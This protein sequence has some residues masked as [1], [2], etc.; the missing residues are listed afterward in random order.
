MVDK[1][2]HQEIQNTA[3]QENI[4]STWEIRCKIIHY[5]DQQILGW[6]TVNGNISISG[7]Y[8]IFHQYLPLLLKENHKMM[9]CLVI[10]I[11]SGA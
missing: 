1:S 6:K 11:E 10:V 5:R 3:F 7:G 9:I 2:Y 8:V 4:L